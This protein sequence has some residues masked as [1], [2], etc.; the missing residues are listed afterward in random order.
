[1]IGQ[2][3]V[4]GWRVRDHDY[5]EGIGH[6]SRETITRSNS[7]GGCSD[8]VHDIGSSSEGVS[9]PGVRSEW[10]E[11]SCESEVVKVRIREGIGVDLESA[12]MALDTCH[13]VHSCIDDWELVDPKDEGGDSA[14]F[15]GIADL[16]GDRVIASLSC[17][18]CCV[19]S[20]SRAAEG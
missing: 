1:M 13:I 2:T 3:G 4:C 10:S 20:L 12:W 18:H 19:V 5:I 9:S 8:G 14:G 15:V 11:G 16:H 17:D 6:T 7:D